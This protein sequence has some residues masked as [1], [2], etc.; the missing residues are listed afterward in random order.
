LSV[1]YNTV[2]APEAVAAREQLWPPLRL[3]YVG[4]IS[5]RKGLHLAI[6]SVRLLRDRGVDAV[7]DIVGAVFPGQEAFEQELRET[8]RTAN[9]SAQV[10]FHGFDANIWPHFEHADIVVIPSIVDESFGNTAVE[11]ALAARPAVVSRVGGL[12]E[13]AAG[14]DAAILIAP[15]SAG[16]IAD[17]VGTMVQDWD[18]FRERAVR[19]ASAAAQRFSPNAYAHGIVRAVNDATGSVSR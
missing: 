1:V 4:R 7:L 11:A 6:D 9:L 18:G 5:A 19:A 12:P 13:A 16:D 14:S 15:G 10:T 8:V 2:Q 17:A 3:L